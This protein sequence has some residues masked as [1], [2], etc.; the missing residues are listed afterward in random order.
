MQAL[1]GALLGAF[2][3]LSV[4]AFNVVMEP[5]DCVGQAERQ[6]NDLRLSEW[7]PECPDLEEDES[8]ANRPGNLPRSAYRLHNAYDQTE[9]ART[10]SA[11][12]PRQPACR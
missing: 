3:S 7:L 11:P 2:Q 1:L 9:V 4:A 12:R 6:A 5:A 10:G 8:Q